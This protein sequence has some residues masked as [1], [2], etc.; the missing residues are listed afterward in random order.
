MFASARI[1]QGALRIALAA[2]AGMMTGNVSGQVAPTA[3]EVSRYAGLHAAAQTGDAAQ[4]ARLV[5][6]KADLN[7]RDSYG[8]TPLHVAAFARQ[9]EAIR[10]LAAAGANLNVLEDDRYAP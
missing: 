4:I 9:R 5:A 3:A 6:G 8:R 7:A 2:G 1:L 10:L